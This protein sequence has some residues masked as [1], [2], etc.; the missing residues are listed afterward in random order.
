MQDLLQDLPPGYI[1]EFASSLWENNSRTCV[2]E[3]DQLRVLDSRFHDADS[4]QTTYTRLP[5]PLH[6]SGSTL[7]SQYFQTPWC[8][9]ACR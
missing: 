7:C 9:V 8:L 1:D 4:D 6:Q 3:D 5:F 2:Y